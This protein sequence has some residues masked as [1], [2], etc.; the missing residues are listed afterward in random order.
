MFNPLGSLGIDIA[1][2]PLLLSLDFDTFNKRHNSSPTRQKNY[3]RKRNISHYR[4][5]LYPNAYLFRRPS[6]NYAP[7]SFR[8]KDRANNTC[9]HDY[10]INSHGELATHPNTTFCSE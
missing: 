3:L 10:C 5:F 8:R 7:P 4:T 1:A 2:V 6:P 9:K